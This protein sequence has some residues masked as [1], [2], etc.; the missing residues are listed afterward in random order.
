MPR[1]ERLIRTLVILGIFCALIYLGQFLW[2]IGQSL[3]NLILLLAMAW[4]VAYVL[5]PIAQWLNDGPIPKPIVG[6]VHRHWGNRPAERLLGIRVPYS[7]AALSLYLLVLLTLTLS[8]VL[9]VP[10]IT[11]PVPQNVGT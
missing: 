11:C 4:L 7:L 6:W 2:Q 1:N 3:S 8:T 9:A 10:G 5:T